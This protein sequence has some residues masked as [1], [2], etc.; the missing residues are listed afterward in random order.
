MIYVK[1]AVLEILLHLQMHL[2]FMQERPQEIGVE[3]L[4]TVWKMGKRAGSLF[5]FIKII[6]DYKGKE[7][8]YKIRIENKRLD[9][10]KMIEKGMEKDKLYLDSDLTLPVFALK[11]G[12]NRTYV[13]E[14]L[15]YRGT[16]FTKF[17]NMYR[18]RYLLSIL[19]DSIQNYE[20]ETIAKKSG[21]RSRRVMDSV[22][23][24]NMG[25]TY[26]DLIK[27]RNKNRIRLK[28]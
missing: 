28:K 3:Q 8:E 10:Y 22:L 16:T 17:V 7:R 9:L 20:A 26:F 19:D 24:E 23:L 5:S 1:C 27:K 21:F 13:C 4:K 14:T 12:T 6:K 25:K 18:L 2:S 11:M 15:K